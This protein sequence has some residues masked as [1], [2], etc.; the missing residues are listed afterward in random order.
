MPCGSGVFVGGMGTAVSVAAKVGVFVGIRTSAAGVA[1]GK[2]GVFVAMGRGVLVGGT[3]VGD[4]G[5]GVLVG[6]G[7]GVGV[8]DGVTVAV[9]VAVRVDEGVGVAVDVGSNVQV[10]VI[11]DSIVNVGT[12]VKVAVA[13]GFASSLST[14]EPPQ[15]TSN[16][17]SIGTN[18]LLMDYLWR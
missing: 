1:V 13:M 6:D 2:V 3:G 14:A 18:Q 17:K 4:A 9:A 8:W 5:R 7:V 15:A 12:T 10:G 16:N 11:V